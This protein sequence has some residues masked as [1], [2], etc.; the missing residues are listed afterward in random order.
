MLAAIVQQCSRRA[1]EGFI[2]SYDFPRGIRD[3]RQLPLAAITARIARMENSD[4]SR[5]RR[6]AK[7]SALTT[8][9]A[10]TVAI[11]S[12]LLIHGPMRQLGGAVIAVSLVIALGAQGVFF[13]AFFVGRL[14]K[15]G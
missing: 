15:V 11:A 9:V 10:A 1:L 8:A 14:Y 12:F 7:L 13:W 5:Y 4:R 2:D 6:I 3:R